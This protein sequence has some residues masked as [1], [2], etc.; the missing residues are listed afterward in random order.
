[1]NAAT[2]LSSSQNPTDIESAQGLFE[3]GLPEDVTESLSDLDSGSIGEHL[4]TDSMPINETID[5]YDR[6]AEGSNTIDKR[7]TPG[8]FNGRILSIRPVQRSS[9]LIAIMTPL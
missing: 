7:G 4:A 9:S 8:V 5:Q 2:S 3:T 6:T 1:M